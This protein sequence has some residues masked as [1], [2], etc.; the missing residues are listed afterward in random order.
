M[1]LALPVCHWGL[2]GLLKRESFYNGRPTSYW[3]QQIRAYCEFRFSDQPKAKITLWFEDF[4]YLLGLPV[5]AAP[6]LCLGPVER[7][8]CRAELMV[9]R[10]VAAERGSRLEKFIVLQFVNSEFGDPAAVPVLI[11]L[12]RDADEFVRLYATRLL[13]TISP[14]A[15]SAVPELREALRREEDNEDNLARRVIIDTL[16]QID[17]LRR[18]QELR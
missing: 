6:P 12:L 13:G 1:V 4:K 18:I 3:S 9:L 10:Q 16:T 15:S 11:E 7:D 14:A 17:A 2:I 5:P 8:N